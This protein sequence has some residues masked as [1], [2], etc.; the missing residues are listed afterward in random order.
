M[1]PL[2]TLALLLPG[3]ILTFH[4][5]LE[6]SNKFESSGNVIPLWIL[7]HLW[8]FMPLL[9][10]THIQTDVILVVEKVLIF[11][12]PASIFQLF[13]KKGQAHRLLR[14]SL[15]TLSLLAPVAAL[16]ELLLKPV[17]TEA[18][19]V[20]ITLFGCSL[21]LLTYFTSLYFKLKKRLLRY[22]IPLL[23]LLIPVS[24]LLLYLSRTDAIPIL[25]LGP[26]L[27]LFLLIRPGEHRINPA[28]SRNG[29]QD[30]LDRIG[31]LIL[32][33]DADGGMLS[34][35]GTA[36]S[37]LKPKKQI[38]GNYLIN[39]F[40]SGSLDPHSDLEGRR[41]LTLKNSSGGKT[42]V[43]ATF[44]P[45]GRQPVQAYIIVCTDLKETAEALENG[46]LL[47]RMRRWRTDQFI[48]KSREERNSL[49]SIIENISDGILIIDDDMNI[50]FC[51][52]ALEELA[53]ISRDDYLG[54]PFTKLQDLAGCR[55]IEEFRY[56]EDSELS[57]TNRRTGTVHD[58]LLSIAPVKI[59]LHDKIGMILTLKDIT[60]QKDENRKKSEFISYASHEISAPLNSIQG[61]AITLKEMD[62]IPV[63]QQME[64][65]QII[66]KEAARLTRI[67]EELLTFSRL[68]T[69][70]K[71]I[72]KRKFR[73]ASLI[74]EIHKEY[75]R[76]AAE[77]EIVLL[78]KLSGPYPPL[79]GDRDKL[80]QVLVNLVTNAV[81]F[82]PQNGT[83][84]IRVEFDPAQKRF[85]IDVL[86]E[87]CG[88]L[89]GEEKRVFD[90]FYR[91]GQTK[92]IVK[93]TGLGLA[94][95]M[96][97]AQKHNGNITAANRPKK[98]AC[99]SLFLPQQ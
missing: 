9:P 79:S 54:Y 61:F 86:D 4:L 35:N 65:L 40:I 81:K 77:R 71:Q 82:S 22:T 98:G 83:V 51:N 68:E 93:G 36:L 72:K 48:E 55:I 96:D 47:E 67:I 38:L 64:Y 97:I 27:M 95:A 19:P 90:K 21:L 80:K 89:P 8:L 62:N 94:I 6:S 56:F 32:I 16:A 26:L 34:M 88:L 74:H 33:M 59:S 92:N 7:S 5:F 58:I 52:R 23:T 14:R 29:T 3:H 53:G 45:V 66:E 17:R 99:F 37:R 60:R 15:F 87:G 20:S 39:D 2:T 12:L 1:N 18:T 49:L 25:S 78:E 63:E 46:I 84:E 31:I 75:W 76:F 10:L 11:S 70:S 50:L 13:R 85:R 42:P 24:A 57:I 41:N 91:S 43:E 30:I 44:I 28:M 73:L 69:S